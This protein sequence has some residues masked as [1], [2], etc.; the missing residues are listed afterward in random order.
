MI[1]AGEHQRGAFARTATHTGRHHA[2]RS[3]RP[4]SL[5]S[6]MTAERPEGS[7]STISTHRPTLIMHPALQRGR[8]QPRPDVTVD[9]CPG[10]PSFKTW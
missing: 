5:R 1:A 6:F 9:A 8:P 10:T 7:V 3:G 4:R 2:L